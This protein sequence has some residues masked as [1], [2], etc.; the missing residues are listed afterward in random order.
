MKT[1]RLYSAILLFSCCPFVLR[2]QDRIYLKNQTE[3]LYV[4]IVE[5]STFLVKYRPADAA[6]PLIIINKKDVVSIVR[7]DG[8]VLPAEKSLEGYAYYEAPRNWVFKVEPYAANQSFSSVYLEKAGRSG[9]S[10]EFKMSLAGNYIDKSTYTSGE[11]RTFE[12]SG[13]FVGA[14]IKFIKRPSW[15][16]E[17]ARN[18]HPLQGAF[19]KPGFSIGYYQARNTG[20]V[21]QL[22]SN[23]S[24]ALGKQWVLYNSF[25]IELYV[26]TGVGIDNYTS[27]GRN[28][29]IA[30]GISLRSN[31]FVR[32]DNLGYS[33]L[34]FAT[35]GVSLQTGFKIGY[36]FNIRKQAEKK[37]KNKTTE[38]KKKKGT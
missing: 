7:Q 20:N 10:Y 37:V 2:A 23:I 3:P 30:D 38:T 34:G 22:S 14:G 25:A 1:A 19:I 36:L 17:S 13:A 16:A 21:G 4:H 11:L 31:D 33:N 5:E 32:Y 28:T 26:S 8:R 27:G 9:R 24:V 6:T 15:Q 12:T 18:T 35:V 29:G